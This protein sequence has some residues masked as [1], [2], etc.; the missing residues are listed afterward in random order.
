MT[1]RS[2][3]LLLV[4][5]AALPAA[6]CGS[7][8]VDP[9]RGARASRDPGASPVG[10]AVGALE[11]SAP[12]SL[13]GTVVDAATGEPLAGARLEGPSGAS[14]VS[15]ADGRFELRGIAPGTSGQ[16]VATMPDGRHGS[17][18]LRSLRSGALEVV[19]FVR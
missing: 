5:S 1:T 8:Q 2:A 13:R 6:G 18:R 4:A 3:L 16:L 10:Y 14:A 11:A 17:N 12:A 19:V 9:E 15:D 7:S